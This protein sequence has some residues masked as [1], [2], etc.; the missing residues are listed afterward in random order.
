MCLLFSSLL[1]TETSNFSPG[2]NWI[3]SFRKS[4]TG[5]RSTVE[6]GALAWL[7]MWNKGQADYL[8]EKNLENINTSW[9]DSD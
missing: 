3:S 2:Y 8:G 7:D 5:L 1:P 4:E 6:D 9:Q